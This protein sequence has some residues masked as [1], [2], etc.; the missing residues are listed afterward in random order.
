MSDFYVNVRFKVVWQFKEFPHYQITKDKQI[1]NTKTNK[2]LVYNQRGFFIGG[3]YH[4]RNQLKQMIE[5]IPKI[6]YCPF[7]N[8]T[9]KI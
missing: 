3:K 6:E 1:I 5:K 2:L 8:G 4:K 7:S 9:I